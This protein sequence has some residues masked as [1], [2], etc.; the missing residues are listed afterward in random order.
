MQGGLKHLG[1]PTSGCTWRDIAQA[2]DVAQ[3]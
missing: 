1:F 3:I 2:E